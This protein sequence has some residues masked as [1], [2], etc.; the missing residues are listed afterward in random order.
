MRVKFVPAD[1]TKDIEFLEVV[2]SPRKEQLR[3]LQEL[4]G[5]RDEALPKRATFVEEVRTAYT[6]QRGF[7]MLVDEDGVFKRLPVN[8]RAQR[9]SSYPRSIVG[10]VVFVGILDGIGEWTDY[11]SNIS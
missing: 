9:L 11:P 6:T 7:V 1:E 8:V 5:V 4:V 10:D 2:N 3:A